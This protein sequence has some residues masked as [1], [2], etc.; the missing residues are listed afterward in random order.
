MEFKSKGSLLGNQEAQKLQ[1]KLQGRPLAEFL[2][3][4]G[5]SISVL[6][7]RLSTNQMRSAHITEGNLLY[8][9]STKLNVNLIQKKK[10][11][12]FTETSRL[13]VDQISVHCVTAKSA[14]K[15]NHHSTPIITTR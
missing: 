10:K 5:S 2:L 14:H 8:S 12:T 15:T 1:W 7:L 6:I 4:W 9:G 13:T 11:I 3:P